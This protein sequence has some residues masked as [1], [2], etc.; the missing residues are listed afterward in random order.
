MILR[1]LFSKNATQ[2]DYNKSITGT[3]VSR[4][5]VIVLVGKNSDGQCMYQYHTFI[6]Q[7]RGN[8]KFSGALEWD[9]AG[10]N[11]FRSCDK[12]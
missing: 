9:G 11:T 7:A 6:Q 4:S 1:S 10:A 5:V 2:W 3:I 12:I 8:G